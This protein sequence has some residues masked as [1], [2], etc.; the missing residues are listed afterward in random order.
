[1]TDVLEI[2]EQRHF[3]P[4]FHGP[5]SPWGR[6]VAGAGWDLDRGITRG[7]PIQGCASRRPVANERSPTSC[8]SFDGAEILSADFVFLVTAMQRHEP[9]ASAFA[10]RG[11]SY[12][13]GA[14]FFR[15]VWARRRS[16][17]APP[18]WSGR[19]PSAPA[20]LPASVNGHRATV[21]AQVRRPGRFRAKRRRGGVERPHERGRRRGASTSVPMAVAR[22]ARTADEHGCTRA[23]SIAGAERGDG[24][25]TTGRAG[26]NGFT[27]RACTSTTA[28]GSVPT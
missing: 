28:S 10:A 17:P 22:L 5:L 16:G 9:A 3:F 24:L 27:A 13:R 21:E 14:M 18:A 7:E 11:R 23:R 4:W 8:R 1:M 19:C 15:I 20:T 6:Q 12:P 25:A 2:D 26:S